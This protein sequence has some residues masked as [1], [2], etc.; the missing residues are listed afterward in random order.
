MNQQRPLESSETSKAPFGGRKIES[1][2]DI[3][4][5][6]SDRRLHAE[7]GEHI[8]PEKSK[9]LRETPDI[10]EKPEEFAKKAREAKLNPEGLL[11]YSSKLEVP[12]H[13]RKGDVG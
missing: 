7:Y 6:L 13:I 3:T 10:V 5:E 12:G 4:R 11:G 1:L 2:D 9:V 8:A